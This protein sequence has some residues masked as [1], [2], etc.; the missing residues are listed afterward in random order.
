M[1]NLKGDI[2]NH[3]GAGMDKT[4]L[5]IRSTETGNY[6]AE[7][8]RPVSVDGGKSTIFSW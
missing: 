7:V 2:K 8:Q 6:R 4:S 1:E 3:L 5:A